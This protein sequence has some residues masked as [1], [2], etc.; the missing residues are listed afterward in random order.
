MPDAHAPS[1]YPKLLVSDADRSVRFYVG[2]GFELVHRDRVFAHLRWALHADVFLVSTPPGLA[3]EGR[4]GVGVI[5]CFDARARGLDEL[6]DRAALIGAS[7]DGPRDTPWHTRELTVL[8]P[9][10]YRLAFVTPA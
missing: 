6:V 9:E 2:L 7:V 10:G 1:A 8:D 4:R 5:L 3:L